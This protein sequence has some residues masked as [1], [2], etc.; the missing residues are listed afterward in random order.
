MCK[1]IPFW[2]CWGL[3]SLSAVRYFHQDFLNGCH[4]QTRCDVQCFSTCLMC[5]HFNSKNNTFSEEYVMVYNAVLLPLENSIQI[6]LLLTITS[7]S[8]PWM[9]LHFTNVFLIVS[10][11]I[12]LQVQSLVKFRLVAIG[13]KNCF[14]INLPP[15]GDVTVDDVSSH[16]F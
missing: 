5:Y 6:Y 16:I 11:S 1:I 14:S 15:E 10:S 7:V 12:I 2:A 4:V 8:V 9:H 13:E 3:I